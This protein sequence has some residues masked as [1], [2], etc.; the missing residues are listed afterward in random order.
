MQ[1]TR[2]HAN[3]VHF[4]TFH[5]GMTTKHFVDSHETSCRRFLPDFRNALI[6]VWDDVIKFTTK[7]NISC[8]QPPTMLYKDADFWTYVLLLYIQ[9]KNT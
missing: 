5:L 3:D 7:Q 4:T 9:Y 8:R 1:T 2:A 6:D